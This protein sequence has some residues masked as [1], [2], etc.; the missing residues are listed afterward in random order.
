MAP[1]IEA[2]QAQSA[3]LVKREDKKTASTGEPIKVLHDYAA[4]M[5]ETLQDPMLHPE[6]QGAMP[7]KMEEA[8][9]N[10]LAAIAALGNMYQGCLND[11][12]VGKKQSAAT[13]A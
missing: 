8:Y 5:R 1:K 11:F 2:L 9:T 3:E 12:E 7:S 4:C 10:A 13:E 6:L